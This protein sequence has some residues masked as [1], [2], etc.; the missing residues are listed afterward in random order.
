MHRLTGERQAEH[1][2]V[3][4]SADPGQVDIDIPEVNLGVLAGPVG[5][6]MN[7]RGGPRPVSTRISG[8][9]LAT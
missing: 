8:L 5:L 7:T 1:E 4:Q 2:P 9:R 3:T 6:R